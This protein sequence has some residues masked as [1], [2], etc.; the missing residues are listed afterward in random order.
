MATL[1]WTVLLYIPYSPDLAPFDFHLL[2][3]LKDALRGCRFAKDD[4]LKHS[5]HEKFDASTKGIC[6]WHT[7]S[8][9]W[10]EKVS[11]MKVLWKHNFNCVKDVPIICVNFIVIVI[12]F[13]KKNRRHYCPTAPLTYM[14]T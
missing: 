8:H 9:A 6:E 2:G 1:E 13:S 11:I 3:L 14:Y 10:V 7:A 4:E 5:V 12:V